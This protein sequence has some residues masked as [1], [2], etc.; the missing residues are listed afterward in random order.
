LKRLWEAE[1]RLVFKRWR[2]GCPARLFVS[3]NLIWFRLV[4][5]HSGRLL[6]SN[7]WENFDAHCGLGD[8]DAG[9]RFG[10]G[11]GSRPDL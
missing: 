10:G 6:L 9:G 2:R 11:P 4:D 5:S 8:F 3:S 1:G 7:R